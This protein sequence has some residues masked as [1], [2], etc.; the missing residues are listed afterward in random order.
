MQRGI[1]LLSAGCVLALL[2]VTGCSSFRE[3]ARAARS[4]PVAANSLEGLWVGRWYDSEKP[5]HGG[6]LK[7]VLTRTGDTLYRASV[8]S[9]WWR[10]FSA[11][12]DTTLI[13]TP[14]EPGAYLLQGERDIWPFGTYAVT[15]RVDATDFR[16]TY[17]VAGHPGVME[18]RRAGVAAPPAQE[19]TAAVAQ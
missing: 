18:L 2:L 11:S 16:A 12:Y 19:P 6:S 8:R 9:R 10:V 7:C 15:G 4:R 14:A 1:P 5:A 3:D 13:L 17:T